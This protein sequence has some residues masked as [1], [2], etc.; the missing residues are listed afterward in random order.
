MLKK[1]LF[2]QNCTFSSFYNVI[3]H[4]YFKHGSV[5]NELSELPEKL[6]YALSPFNARSCCGFVVECV[7]ANSSEQESLYMNTFQ[8]LRGQDYR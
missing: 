2:S 8:P 3:L 5:Q 1:E 6:E 4:D 7:Y